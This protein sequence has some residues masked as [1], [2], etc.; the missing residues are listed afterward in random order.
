VYPVGS[1]GRGPDPLCGFSC[2]SAPL[3]ALRIITETNRIQLVISGMQNSLSGPYLAANDSILDPLILHAPV[4]PLKPHL[5]IPFSG[6]RSAG[7]SGSE[8]VR[9]PF[10]AWAL[11]FSTLQKVFLVLLSV[12]NWNELQEKA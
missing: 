8:G 6:F 3:A 1:A 11:M 4:V 7:M 10:G 5:C 12:R 9:P 2:D